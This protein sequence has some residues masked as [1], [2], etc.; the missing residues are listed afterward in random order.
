MKINKDKKVAVYFNI[1]KG[2]FSVMQNGLVGDNHTDK[3]A[4]SDAEFVVRKGGRM[5]FVVT[6]ERMFTLSS[7]VMSIRRGVVT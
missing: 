7:R 6:R 5:L 3:I 4:L 1:T 2:C